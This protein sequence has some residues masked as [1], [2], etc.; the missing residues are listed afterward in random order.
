MGTRSI[1]TTTEAGVNKKTDKHTYTHAR[2][3]EFQVL[4]SKLEAT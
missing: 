2:K 1:C 3:G 4:E